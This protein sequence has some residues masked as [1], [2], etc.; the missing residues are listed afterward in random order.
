DAR[1]S[2][3]AARAPPRASSAP[4]R[5]GGPGACPARPLRP[6]GGRRS[7]PGSPLAATTEP[8]A[9]GFVADLPAHPGQLLAEGIGPLEVLRLTCRLAPGQRTLGPPGHPRA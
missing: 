7:A 8:G 1:V 5:L 6:G 2:R 3:R 9:A 4:A